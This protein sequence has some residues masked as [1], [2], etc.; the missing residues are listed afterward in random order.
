MNFGLVAAGAI[1][2]HGHFSRPSWLT[3]AG[4]LF[5]TLAGAS[6]FLAYYLV[7][8]AAFAADAAASWSA[9]DIALGPAGLAVLLPDV[10]AALLTMPTLGYLLALSLPAAGAILLPG[11]LAVKDARLWVGMLVSAAI[12][13]LG[14]H[15]VCQLLGMFR[16][17]PPPVADFIHALRF[18]MLP[19]YVLLA[20]A[21]VQLTRLGLPRR[22]L[23]VTLAAVLAVWLVPA[24]NLVAAR[25]WVDRTAT[26]IMR[27]QERSE[28][29]RRRLIEPDRGRELAAIGDYLWHNTPID[30]V[31]I[32]DQGRLRL[33]SRRALVVCGDD[34]KYLYYLAPRR[35]A[36]WA[37]VGAEQEEALSPKS[38][39]PCDPRGLERFARRHG[40]EFAVVPAEKA[41]AAVNAPRW[42][43]LENAAWGAQWKLYQLADRPAGK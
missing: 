30:T 13:G 21:I 5:C 27:E 12:V 11:R 22:A 35:L 14:L 28:P 15:G 7:Q 29:M 42:T 8:R 34:V 43:E 41:F 31:I 23:R 3:A 2:V 36:T 24:D 19:L 20:E 32:C 26:G 16:D 4:G 37:A 6:P 33:W 10:L 38:G 40:A 18:L 17:Q 39:G 25:Q 1:L 9:A